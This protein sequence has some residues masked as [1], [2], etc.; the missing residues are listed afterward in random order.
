MKKVLIFFFLT[1]FYA[2]GQLEIGGDAVY[3]PTQLEIV[4]A[5]YF[6]NWSIGRNDEIDETINSSEDFYNDVIVNGNGDRGRWDNFHNSTSVI[7]NSGPDGRYEPHYQRARRYGSGDYPNEVNVSENISKTANF[8]LILGKAAEMH[9]A[10]ISFENVNPEGE[11]SFNGQNWKLNDLAEELANAVFLELIWYAESDAL[12]ASNGGTQRESGEPARQNSTHGTFSRFMYN[13]TS[14]FG[15]D[16]LRTGA[17]WWVTFAKM[18]KLVHAYGKVK[19]L[20]VGKQIYEDNKLKVNYWFKDWRDFCFAN[21]DILMKT[22]LDSNWRDFDKNWNIGGGL[23]DGKGNAQS[24]THYDSNGNGQNRIQGNL[25]DVFNNRE[26]DHFEYL[27]TYA[28]YFGDEELQDWMYD[29]WKAF[30]AVYT[31]SDGTMYEFYRGGTGIPAMQY[32]HIIIVQLVSMAQTHANAVI[33]NFPNV[34]TN[35]RKFYDYESSMGSDELS[36]GDWS[37]SSSGGNKGL[38]LTMNNILRHFQN[39]SN[40]GWF[41]NRYDE[42]GVAIPEDPSQTNT[43]ASGLANLYYDNNFFRAGN[44]RDGSMGLNSYSNHGSG[45]LNGEWGQAW[46]LAGSLGGEV[47]AYEMGGVLADDIS[48]WENDADRDSDNEEDE[49]EEEEEEENN[50]EENNDEEGNTEEEND[51]EESDNA[52]EEENDEAS[53][54]D[55]FLEEDV[56][57]TITAEELDNL[58][59]A[60]NEF[61]IAENP[62]RDA[63]LKIVKSDDECGIIS[64]YDLNARLLHQRNECGKQLSIPIDFI[65]SRGVYVVR[66]ERQSRTDVKRF[67]FNRN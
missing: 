21:M 4:T 33:N 3:S 61:F 50:D 23:F 44:V 17:P 34:G 12:D 60:N 46:W 47:A 41:L 59:E 26:N 49:Q 18:S 25:W 35:P 22:K 5:R 2:Q 9:N 38:E 63:T 24:Y 65:L 64:I 8:A 6:N 43:I 45:G 7:P 42:S 52:E 32:P 56:D 62:V 31:W 51:N 57:D 14:I 66:V 53:D 27:H 20:L 1:V 37:D 48:A 39:S 30:Y 55:D 13:P 54:V 40:G 10:G 11:I 16:G 29:W 19:D 58:L 15:I 67:L 28:T 36:D